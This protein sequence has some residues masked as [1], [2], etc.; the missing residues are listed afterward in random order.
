MQRTHFDCRIFLFVKKKKKKKIE[1]GHFLLPVISK[2]HMTYTHQYILIIPLFFYFFVFFF[3]SVNSLF[4]FF[5]AILS[6]DR[7]LQASIKNEYFNYMICW[8]PQSL[9]QQSLN[10][11]LLKMNETSHM[12]SIVS[13]LLIILMFHTSHALI[14]HA[15][16]RFPFLMPNVRPYRVS[17]NISYII[18]YSVDYQ[19]SIVV[20]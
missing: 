20:R 4:L 13:L 1:Q 15:V 16:G 9:F 8:L 14:P 19:L 7:H 3:I 11:I 17:K 18:H 12:V 6:S 5:H 2:S 10:Y